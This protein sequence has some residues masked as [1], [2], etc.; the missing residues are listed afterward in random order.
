MG[1]RAAVRRAIGRVIIERAGQTSLAQ[2]VPDQVGSNID[3]THARRPRIPRTQLLARA[4]TLIV[5]LEMLPDKA[6]AEAVRRF[7]KG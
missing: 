2:T 6:G 7:P 3:R 1:E 4:G 5:F